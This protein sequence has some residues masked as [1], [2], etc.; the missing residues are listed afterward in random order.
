M[1]L[2]QH[3]GAAR[4]RFGRATTLGPIALLA[5][6]ALIPAAAHA[7]AMADRSNLLGGE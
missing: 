7:Q 2:D 6:L 5:W 3:Q 4:T 1:I